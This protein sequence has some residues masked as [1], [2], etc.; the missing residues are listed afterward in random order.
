MYTRS[1]IGA[2]VLAL[3]AALAGCGGTHA[4]TGARSSAAAARGD[5]GA[6]REATVDWPLWGGSYEN[7]RFSTLARLDADAVDRLTLAWSRSEGPEQFAW[8]TF[9]VV[10]GEVMYYDTDTDEVLAVNA[11]TG[12]QLW[13]YQPQ[14]DFLAGAQGT[15][16]APVSRGVTVANGHVYELTFDDQLIALDARTGERQWDVSVADAAAG[17]NET[18]PPTY[19]RGEL[20]LGGPA[21]DSGLRG[22]VAAYTAASG[23]ALWRTY[24][25]PAPGHGWNPAKGQHGGGD[26][27]MRPTVDEHSGT[28]YVATGDPTPAFSSARR[29]GCDRWSDSTVALDARTGRIEWGHSE[30]C[31]DSWDYDTDQSPMLLSVRVRGRPREAVGDGSKSGFYS[32]LDASSGALIARSPYITRYSLPHRVPDR[33]G[34]VVCPGIFGGIEYGPPAYSPR[35]GEVYV[36]GSNMCM[37]YR[38]EPR[39]KIERHRAGEGDL[40]GFAE[41][42]GPATGVI[43]AV[44]AASGRIA[45]KTALPRPAAGGALATAGGLVFAGDDDGYLYAFDDRTGAIVWRRHLGLRFGSAPFAYAIDG[46]D[47]LAVAA[48]GSALQATGDAPGGGTLF[49]F[50]LGRG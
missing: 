36:P 19:W 32:T 24:M 1:F 7:T 3:A 33:A 10:V 29:A 45:W 6:A 2:G 12:R 49:V 44:D 14:V 38:V 41:Q 27:W 42:A 31:G 16:A 43:A 5:A 13:S 25:V 9:P 50:R 8:E 15:T 28:V 37:R 47:Y 35:T 11:V 46:V 4:G 40:E 20:I 30:I 26:V 21:G 48:G 17:Y 23:R 34:A 22:F 39:T 18:S